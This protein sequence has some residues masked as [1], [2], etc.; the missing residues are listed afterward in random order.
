MSYI[1]GAPKATLEAFLVTAN[2]GDETAAAEDLTALTEGGDKV[3]LPEGRYHLYVPNRAS[4][5]P[6]RGIAAL[7][8][9]LG[10]KTEDLWF[11]LSDRQLDLG[12]DPKM[13]AC[14]RHLEADTPAD[15]PQP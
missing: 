2:K 11:V 5:V 12:D 15:E 7:D 14:M 13:V 9:T 4:K 1:Y 6:K 8:T 10:R 3:T